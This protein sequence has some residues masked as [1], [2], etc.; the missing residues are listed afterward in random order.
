MIYE[1]ELSKTRVIDKVEKWYKEVK[2][3]RLEI[4]KDVQKVSEAG[5]ENQKSVAKVLQRKT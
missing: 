5:S 2:I 4:L 3:I 1:I